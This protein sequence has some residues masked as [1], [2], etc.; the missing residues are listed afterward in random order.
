MSGDLQGAQ[1][2]TWMLLGRLAFRILQY[3]IS[4]SPGVRKI[5]STAQKRRPPPPP[6]FS[7]VPLVRP[8]ALVFYDPHP[9][10]QVGPDV[11]GDDLVPGADAA[12][13]PPAPVVVGRL[14]GLDEPGERQGAEQLALDRPPGVLLDGEAVVV[15]T[16]VGHL[17]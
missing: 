4:P 2:T 15:P 12:V 10:R 13:R 5:Q 6:T 1:A 17:E 8:T 16:E 9:V 11:D 3:S 7:P 14:A